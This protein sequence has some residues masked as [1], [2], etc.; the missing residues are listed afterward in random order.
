MKVLGNP[1]RCLSRTTAFP[2]VL[3]ST[4]TN[5]LTVAMIHYF[6]FRPPTIGIGIHKSRYSFELIR[7]ERAF[8]VNIPTA[9][10]IEAVQICGSK[11]G[12]EV[13]K[14]QVARL[15]KVAASKISSSLIAECPVNIEC[16]VVRELPLEERTWFIGEVVAVHEEQG[17]TSA[18]ALIYSGSYYRRIGEVIGRR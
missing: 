2:V 3:I 11:S 13:D 9:Q 10:Q 12:R 18:D 1:E 6:S 7:G 14:F 8:S 16:Q 17:Y 15:T 4:K 5:I